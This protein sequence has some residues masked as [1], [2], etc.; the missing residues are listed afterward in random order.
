M[1]VADENALIDPFTGELI[2]PENA[3]HL[4]DSLERL[5]NY[6]ESI[7]AWRLVIEEHI[8]RK[9]RNAAKTERVNGERRQVVIEHPGITFD[10]RSLKRLWE[11]NPKF[12]KLYLRI[13]QVGVQKREYDKLNRMSGPQDQEEFRRELMAAERVS[14]SKPRIKIEK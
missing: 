2:D 7:K 12:A 10:Q 6:A 4:I 5:D 11:D 1:S 3:D 9:T 13:E 14:T 8:L